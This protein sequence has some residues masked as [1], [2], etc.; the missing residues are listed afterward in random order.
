[1][2]WLKIDGK[3]LYTPL[4]IE[5]ATDWRDYLMVKFPDSTIEVINS[6]GGTIL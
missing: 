1:M 3:I 5:Y 6:M 4:S 2:Y